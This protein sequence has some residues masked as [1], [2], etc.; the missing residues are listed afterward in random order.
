MLIEKSGRPEYVYTM[1]EQGDII[2]AVYPLCTVCK[3]RAP[4]VEIYE[5]SGSQLLW[6][7]L[8]LCSMPI[9]AWLPF[10]LNRCNDKRL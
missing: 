10:C 6:S 2:E 4:L 1:N 7:C 8:L 9:L 5:L 3:K